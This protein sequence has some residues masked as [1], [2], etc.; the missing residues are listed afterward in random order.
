MHL[1][2]S[3]VQLRPI[4]V[5]WVSVNWAWRSGCSW[6]VYVCFA[7]A[8]GCDCVMLTDFIGQQQ[9]SGHAVIP[10]I[11]RDMM[12]PS[13]FDTVMNYAFVSRLLESPA[14]VSCSKLFV[15]TVATCIY[16]V[17]GMAGYLMFG[18]DV[19]DEVRTYTPYQCSYCFALTHCMSLGQPELTRCSWVQPN[20]EH[21]RPLDASR[22]ASLKIRPCRSTCKSTS[23]SSSSTMSHCANDPLSY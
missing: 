13:Q 11:A 20:S 19:Y 4:S 22:S 21:D 16:A 5:S 15:Q 7:S 14:L 18:N 1:A 8:G 17:I 9:F 3:G 12:E 10:S 23:P 6:L 2:V